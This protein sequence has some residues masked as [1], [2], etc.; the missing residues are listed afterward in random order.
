MTSTT[1]CEIYPTLVVT[2]ISRKIS[3]GLSVLKLLYH[4][5]SQERLRTGQI[6][7]QSHIF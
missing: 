7:D 2:V 6:P 5:P 4:H 3:S 1:P